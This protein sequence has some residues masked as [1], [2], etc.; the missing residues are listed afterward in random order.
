MLANRTPIKINLLLKNTVLS[1]YLFGIS[2]S[3]ISDEI[4]SLF[5]HYSLDLSKPFYDMYFEFFVR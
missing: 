4:L 5:M 1:T 3:S 2:Y